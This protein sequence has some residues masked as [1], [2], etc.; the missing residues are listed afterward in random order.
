[1]KAEIKPKL[2]LSFRKINNFAKN[3]TYVLTLK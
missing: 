1:M 3:Q 2:I